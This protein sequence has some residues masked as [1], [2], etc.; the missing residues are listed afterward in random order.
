MSVVTHTTRRN[1]EGLL[2]REGRAGTVFGLSVDVMLVA[3][4]AFVL[5]LTFWQ[6]MYPGYNLTS[7]QTVS[8]GGPET[9][10]PVMADPSILS[11][12]NAFDRSLST[13]VSVEEDAPETPLNLEIKGL[14]A[15]VDEATSLVR[16]LT[17][18]NETRRYRVGDEIVPNVVLESV[19]ADRVILTREGQRE[20][21]YKYDLDERVFAGDNQ[22]TDSSPDTVAVADS[23]TLAGRI[24][25]I[26]AFYA[27][28]DAQRELNEDGDPRILIGANGDAEKLAMIGLQT[29]DEI[30]SVNGFN[31]ADKSLSDLN[32]SLLGAQALEIE[33]VRNGRISTVLINVGPVQ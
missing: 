13:I 16:I 9:R 22:T 27:A 6:L 30:V 28:L 21:L 31:L 19:L 2:R 33:R 26:P 32:E 1:I 15:G 18:D 8:L 24:A 23:S 12:F 7:V 5:A 17:P 14:F 20:T 11:R 25:N 10:R 3:A 4:I 29:G